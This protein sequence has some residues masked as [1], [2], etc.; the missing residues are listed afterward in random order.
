MAPVDPPT[1]PFG[2]DELDEILAGTKDGQDIFDT[3]N[4]NT[5]ASLKTLKA[6][7]SPGED[8]LGLDE[9]VKVTKQRQ[10]IPKL[11][12]KLLLSDKGIPKLRK[13]SKERLR[14]KGKGHEVRISK[15]MATH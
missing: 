12:A 8:I 7:K 4:I 3:D 13:I 15:A 11:D 2:D 1:A 5:G 6:K 10:P 14:L 9:E